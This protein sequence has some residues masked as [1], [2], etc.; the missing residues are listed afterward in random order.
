MTEW[1][2]VT[3]LFAKLAEACNETT[4][5]VVDWVC[6]VAKTLC[7]TLDFESIIQA[8]AYIQAQKEHPEWV[9]KAIHCKK[10]RIR[11]KYHDRIMRQYWRAEDAMR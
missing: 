7:E 3:D 5:A 11:K 6:S 9:H 10:K 1:E 8:L 4:K 2:Q